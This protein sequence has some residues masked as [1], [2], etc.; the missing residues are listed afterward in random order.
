MFI[1]SPNNNLENYRPV[2]LTSALGNLTDRVI[3][4]SVVKNPRNTEFDD[5]VGKKI[6]RI[7]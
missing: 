1:K 6:A 7:L 5:M 2:R 4:N 3:K